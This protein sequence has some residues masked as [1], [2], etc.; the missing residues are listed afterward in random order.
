MTAQI[1]R[2]TKDWTA[3][4]GEPVEVEE[5]GGSYYGFCSE[6]GALRLFHKYAITDGR[7]KAAYS[8]GQKSWFFRLEPKI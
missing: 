8:P 4:A 2:I 1:N 7:A 5:I 3:I 6:L